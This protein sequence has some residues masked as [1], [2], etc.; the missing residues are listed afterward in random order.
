MDI[1]KVL[2][3]K[4]IVNGVK[5]ED[6]KGFIE[7]GQKAYE[8]AVEKTKKFVDGTLTSLGVTKHDTVMM[9]TG[10]V[11][12]NVYKI[13][14]NI[15]EYYVETSVP[16]RIYSAKEGRYICMLDKTPY[17]SPEVKLINRLYAL[18]NDSVIA[19]EVATLNF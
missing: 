11:L 3:N 15:R 14:G 1:V 10:T 2:V 4:D 16:Y 13:K 9:D 12:N 17:V 18:K 8:E 6:L 19:T 7:N 5:Y